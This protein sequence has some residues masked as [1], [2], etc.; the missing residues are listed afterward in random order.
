MPE[1][2]ICVEC[3]GTL[4]GTVGADEVTPIGREACPNCGGTTFAA[5]DSE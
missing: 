3:E 2:I 1:T 4:L 5:I